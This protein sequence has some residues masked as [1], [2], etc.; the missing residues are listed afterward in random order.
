M[1]MAVKAANRTP[2]GLAADNEQLRARLEE[3][4]ETL[5]AIR[6]GEVDALIV[7]TADGERVFTLEGADRSYRALIEDMNEGAI[8]LTPDGMVLYA[9]RRFAAMLRMPLEKVIGSSIQ[10]WVAAQS[11]DALQALLPQGG[12]SE[13]RQELMLTAGDGTLVPVYMSVNVV[14][15]GGLRDSVGLVATDLTEQKKHEEAIA[16]AEKLARESLEVAN[17]SRTALL[18]IIE[19]QKAVEHAL[20]ASEARFRNVFENS[21]LGK[22]LASMDGDLKLNKAF[23]DILGYSEEDLRR[24]SWKEITYPD[25]APATEDAIRRLLGGEI[26]SARLEKRYIHKNGGLVWADV[27]I[28]IA[29]DTAGKPLY[30]LTAINDITARKQADAAVLDL[31][32]HLQGNI[33]MERLRLAQN[34]HDVPL[35]ELYGVIYE[36]EELRSESENELS[37]TL[38]HVIDNVQKTL[39]SLRAT[40]SELRPPTLSRFGLEKALRSY[41]QDFRERNPQILVRQ[42]LAHDHQLLPESV[43]LVLFRVVQESLTNVVRH[44]QATEVEVRFNF[45]AEEARIEITDNGVGF[46]VPGNWVGMVRAGHYGLAGMAERVSAAG[47]MLSLESAPGTST[48]IRAVIPYSL[49]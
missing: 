48:T 20:R 3:A 47:G 43:R 18:R 35:Q 2:K 34:L 30:I 29:R 11:Q 28:T 14:P 21:P 4:E 15:I 17:Q 27:T 6:A 39:N 22:S 26:Q 38:G 9:N 37:Q 25:D 44:A 32:Q 41:L 36:L 8:R 5:R 13:C 12:C 16:A 10:S 23:C 7:A 31:K 24:K 42:S 46:A 33:E 1:D 40:A 45:D 19:E 49:A